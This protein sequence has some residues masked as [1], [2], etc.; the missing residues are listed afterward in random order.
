MEKLS[1]TVALLQEHREP[2]EGRASRMR[3]DLVLDSFRVQGDVRA[4]RALRRLVDML[5][6]IDSP[7]IV[8]SNGVMDDPGHP[9]TESRHFGIIHVQRDSIMFAVPR[10]GFVR[11]AH[12]FKRVRKVRTSATLA[13]PG[14][15]IVGTIHLTPGATSS[16]P[17]TLLHERFIPVTDAIIMFQGEGWTQLEPVVVVNLARVQICAL[18]GLYAISVGEHLIGRDLVRGLS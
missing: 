2:Q 3:L 13:L 14:V 16:E 8:L 12:P 17:P 11:S 9:G 15:K 1:G 4:G 6:S 18:T 10:G 7:F 5:N